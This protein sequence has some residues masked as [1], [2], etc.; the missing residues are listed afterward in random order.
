MSSTEKNKELQDE[1]TRIFNERK[2]PYNPVVDIGEGICVDFCCGL[3]VLFPASLKK[4]KYQLDVA[5]LDTGLIL[6]SNIL[7]SGE[8]YISKRKYFVRY[9]LKITFEDGHEIC[10][11]YNAKD[12]NVLIDIPVSTIGDTIAWFPAIVEFQKLHRCKIH[13]CMLDSVRELFEEVYP[14]IHFVSK[15]QKD[16]IKPYAY[17]RM[18]IFSDDPEMCESPV[19]YRQCALHHY[20]AYLLGV[21]TSATDVPP[22]IAMKE[23][24]NKPDVPFVCISSFGSGLC[25]NWMNP[26][27]W[28]NTVNFLKDAGYRVIDIDR[29]DIYGSTIY[30]S[31]IPRDAEDFTGD[32][33]LKERAWLISNSAFFV[34]LSSGLSWLAWC[35][36]VPV[37][38]ISGFTLPEH[39]FFTPYRVTN[40]KVCHGCLNDMRNQFNYREFDWCPRH[41]GTS[42]HFECTRGITHDMVIK[43][44]Q[45]ISSFENINKK[46][47][48][49]KNE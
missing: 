27:G 18:A 29:Q 5:D 43:T 4:Q 20:A 7:E 8:Y 47:K 40:I 17:Y 1:M 42:R 13:V 16:K 48:E 11:E 3:R 2:I 28:K 36:K 35:C 26:V 33:S 19:D 23:P 44:I 12:E 39:E 37:V 31:Q 32:F 9:A 49:R 25:K 45:K 22:R 30:W 15:Q 38:M 21:N 10:Y 46:R 6:E 24:K 14:E 41:K 34:G